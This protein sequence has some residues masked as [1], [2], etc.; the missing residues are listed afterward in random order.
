MARKSLMDALSEYQE[1]NEFGKAQKKEEREKKMGKRAAKAKVD[2]KKAFSTK[3]LLKTDKVKP[4][5]KEDKK[6]PPAARRT[7]PPPPAERRTPPPPPAQNNNSGTR[8]KSL[9]SN[10]QLKSQGSGTRGKSLPS[11]PKLKSQRRDPE[12][13]VPLTP[14]S[15]A[16]KIT[17]HSDKSQTKIVNGKRYRRP[18]KNAPWKKG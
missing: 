9:P 3:A 13:G 1:G 7:P 2:T 15:K 17:T 10:P 4:I 8:G 6:D 12:S 5:K 11:N 16:T 18:N 14:R